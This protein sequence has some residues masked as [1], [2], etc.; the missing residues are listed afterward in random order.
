MWVMLED[1]NQ[2]RNRNI[3]PLSHLDQCLQL[4]GFRHKG[5]KYECGNIS[6]FRDFNISLEKETGQGRGRIEGMLRM[7]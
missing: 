4:L 7:T 5:R 1:G 2:T 6:N 3:M